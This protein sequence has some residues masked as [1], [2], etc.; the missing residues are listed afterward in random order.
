MVFSSMVFK[1][2]ICKQDHFS[3]PW[4]DTE[5]QDHFG[6]RYRTDLS[7]TQPTGDIVPPGAVSWLFSSMS[8]EEPLASI[9]RSPFRD[10]GDVDV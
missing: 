4:R 2:C 9:D 3:E 5:T 1:M 6:T 7:R 10:G 8:R